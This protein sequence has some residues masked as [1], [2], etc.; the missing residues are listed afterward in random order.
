[1]SGES[2]KSKKV[3]K[4]K[5]EES[6]KRELSFSEKSH[7]FFL[8]KYGFQ[9]NQLIDLLDN[10][11]TLRDFFS[12]QKEFFPSFPKQL[13]RLV[14]EIQ[15]SLDRLHVEGTLLQWKVYEEYS[16][17]KNAL[18]LDEKPSSEIQPE[19]KKEYQQL[20]ESFEILSKKIK[21]YFSLLKEYSEKL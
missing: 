2:L 12:E 19:I 7:I 4:K 6:K 9:L 15:F 18:R 1:M 14:S 5:K 10:V 20:K 21:E 16:S 13:K 17:I 11:S 8:K 3:E